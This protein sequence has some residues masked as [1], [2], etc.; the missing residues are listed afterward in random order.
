[1]ALISSHEIEGPA[2]RARALKGVEFLEAPG[3]KL[4]TGL[5]S[6]SGSTSHW[7]AIPLGGAI[8]ANRQVEISQDCG[9]QTAGCEAGQLSLGVMTIYPRTFL[10]LANNSTLKARLGYFIDND[11]WQSSSAYD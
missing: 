3:G 5:R 10:F 11:E 7:A 1:M 8:Q 6:T 2:S 9:G 4:R